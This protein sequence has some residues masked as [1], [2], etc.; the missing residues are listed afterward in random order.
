MAVDAGIHLATFVNPEAC[1]E[2]LGEL[3]LVVSWYS[4]KIPD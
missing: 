3:T 1:N 2:G 4:S